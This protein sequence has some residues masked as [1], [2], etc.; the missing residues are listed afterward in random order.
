LRV[1]LGNQI[2][3]SSNDSGLLAAQQFVAG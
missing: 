1:L 3:I 2:G